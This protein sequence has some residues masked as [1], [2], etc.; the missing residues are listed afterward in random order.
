MSDSELNDSERED[1]DFA[2]DPYSSPDDS[3]D[4]DDFYEDLNFVPFS[5]ASL[6]V[7]IDTNLTSDSV[8]PRDIWCSCGLCTDCPKKEA[9]CCRS[10]D[11]LTDMYED[12]HECITST[13]VFIGLI[14]EGIEYSRFIH[15]SAIRDTKKRQE[16]LAKKMTNGLRRHLLYR[17]FVFVLSRGHPYGKNYRIVLPRCV[18]EKIRD[19]YPEKNTESYT[20]FVEPL[21]EQE[22]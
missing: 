4:Y 9:V 3:S 21:A 19:K 17:N 12:K 14:S 16:Y 22:S 10:M 20:G 1:S 18:V 5:Q 2:D 8:Q 13:D 7:N 6:G 15:A 11:E